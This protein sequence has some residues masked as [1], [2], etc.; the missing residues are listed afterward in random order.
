MNGVCVSVLPV[1]GRNESNVEPEKGT[2]KSMYERSISVSRP[3]TKPYP[4]TRTNF[5]WLN[6]AN[7]NV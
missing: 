1:I 2:L 6:P 3:T 4:A 5:H 7:E